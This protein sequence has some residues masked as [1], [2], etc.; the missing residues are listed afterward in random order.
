MALEDKN[1]IKRPA[2]YQ[3]N[4]SFFAAVINAFDGFWIMVVRERNFR[5]HVAI[6]F[7]M[8]LIGLKFNLNR[9]DWLWVTIGVTLAII[10]EILNTIIESVVD[11]VV[12]NEYN[13]TAKIAKDVA[14]SGVVFAVMVEFLIFFIILQPYIWNYFGIH[15]VFTK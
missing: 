7:V 3:R 10:S 11:L 2:S 4:K 13:E 12:G 1:K 14:S 9:S 15:Q 8:F 5:I 6:A